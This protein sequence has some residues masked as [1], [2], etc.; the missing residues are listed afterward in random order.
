MTKPAL[1][2][3]GRRSEQEWL[4]VARPAAGPQVTTKP[5]LSPGGRRSEQEWL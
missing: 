4:S 1:S 5:A 3:G 2:P